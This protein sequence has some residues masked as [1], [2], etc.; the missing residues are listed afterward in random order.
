MMITKWDLISAYIDLK[1]D[2]FIRSDDSKKILLCF[3]DYDETLDI[4]KLWKKD[5]SELKGMVNKVF[6]EEK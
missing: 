5:Y 6:M 2:E 4:D 3:R 1:V